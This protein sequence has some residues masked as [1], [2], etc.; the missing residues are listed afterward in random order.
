M[1]M[2]PTCHLPICD[3]AWFI[4]DY[5][6]RILFEI[7]RI[8]ILFVN[9]QPDRGASVPKFGAWDETDP[10][11]ADGFTHIFNRVK[12]E[13][14]GD[15]GNVTSVATDSRRSNGQKHHKSN[16]SK[17]HEVVLLEYVV[18]G[19]TCCGHMIFMIANFAYFSL[20]FSGLLL[21][22]LG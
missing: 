21:L 12:E 15:A 5:V 11:S 9:L 13:R 16:E 3:S 7:L 18:I 22:S 20:C 6:H 4:R 1:S 8:V 2:F 10:S 19:P 17:V 14:H